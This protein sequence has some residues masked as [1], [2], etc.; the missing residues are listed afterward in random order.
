M[1]DGVPAADAA[2]AAETLGGATQVAQT[3]PTEQAQALLASAHEAF[4]SGVGTT[5]WIGFGLMLVASVIALVAL[6]SARA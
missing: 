5:S 4:G 2:A 3:L 6:R 1:P